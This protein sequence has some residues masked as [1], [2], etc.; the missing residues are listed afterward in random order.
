MWK[1]GYK[2]V[3]LKRLKQKHRVLQNFTEYFKHS[4]KLP[5]ATAKLQLQCTIMYRVGQKQT[6]FSKF[7]TPVYVD[8]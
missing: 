1:I 5:K 7:V 8:I 2:S 6:V 4:L 3:D